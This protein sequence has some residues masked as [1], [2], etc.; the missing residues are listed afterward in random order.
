MHRP[1]RRARALR[2][3]FNLR[4]LWVVIWPMLVAAGLWLVLALTFWETFSN[5]IAQ[6]LD[7]LGVRTWLAGLEPLWLANGIQVV[8]Q[9]L[10]FVPLVYLTALIITALFAMPVLIRVVAERDYP[11]LARA[12][13]GSLVGNLWN[14]LVALLLFIAL[15]GVTLPL[16]LMGV[17]VLVPFIAAAYLNQRLFRYDALAEHASADEMAALF[18][19]ERGGWWG[20]GLLTGL[21]QFVPLLNLLGPVFAALAFI[22]YGLARLRQQRDASV[23]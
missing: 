8:L 9:L 3:L 19:S 21:L 16:W 22:H 6:G 11:E 2:D 13:G 14:A 5:W 17:G 12:S 10:L 4:V 7:S 18:K 20:L 1:H 23:A 15:W